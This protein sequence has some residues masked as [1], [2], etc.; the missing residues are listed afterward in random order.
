MCRAG[1]QLED[2]HR[3]NGSNG[4][5]TLPYRARLTPLAQDWVKSKRL[6]LGYSDAEAPA[7]QTTSAGAA[8]SAAQQPASGSIV[9]WCDGPG[10]PAKAALAAHERESPLRLLDMPHESRATAAVIKA[11]ATKIK[12]E[13]VEGAVLMVQTGAAALVFAKRAQYL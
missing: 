2:L 3:G 1:G 12:S 7:P 6:A 13:R 5:V 11:I 10:G 9:W 4:H 8:A